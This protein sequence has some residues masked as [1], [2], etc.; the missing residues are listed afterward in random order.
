MPVIDGRVLDW[1]L[2][3]LVFWASAQD[4]PIS[5]RTTMGTPLAT[6]VCD[7]LLI[8]SPFLWTKD[9]YLQIR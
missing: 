8:L 9:R 5:L 1:V 6:L 4:C 7:W 3:L 2:C